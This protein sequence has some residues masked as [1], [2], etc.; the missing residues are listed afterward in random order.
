MICI[1]RRHKGDFS[2][3]RAETLKFSRA[4]AEHPDIISNFIDLIKRAYDMAG[5]D[6][7]SQ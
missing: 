7:K 2:T 4:Q 6:T 3:K 5:I 1:L